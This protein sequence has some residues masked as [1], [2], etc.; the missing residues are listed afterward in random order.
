[1]VDYKDI[2]QKVCD[3][4][5]KAGETIRLH[6]G[7]LEA[8]EITVKGKHDLVTVADKESEQLIVSELKKIL[9]GAGFIAEEGT[10][11]NRGGKYNWII[12][13]LDGTTNFVH[14]IAPYA[15]SIALTEGDKTVIGVVYEVVRDECFYACEGDGAYLNGQRINVSETAEINDC[16][17]ATGFPFRNYDRLTPFMDVLKYFILNTRGVRRLGAA[18]VDLAY[19]A[20]GRFDFFFEYDLKPWDVAAGAYIVQ[21]AGGVVCDFGENDN[22]I[23][24]KEIV[25]S[26]PF[27]Y[28]SAIKELKPFGKN[29]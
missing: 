29:D 7:K 13:P 3:I 6:A 24:G 1:M 9:P 19:I 12:D 26:N 17:I 15:V 20:A 22:Y 14:G 27:I 10:E 21:R 4:A 28:N 16:L 11:T 25:A 23:F 8:G 5:K 2:C 18:A